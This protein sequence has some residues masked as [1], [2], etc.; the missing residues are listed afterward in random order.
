MHV[1][2]L[3]STHMECVCVAGGEGQNTPATVTPQLSCRSVSDLPLTLPRRNVLQIAPLMVEKA[4]RA[5]AD[6]PEG[7]QRS[8]V[9][10]SISETG[11]LVC[12][13]PC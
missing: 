6:K 12:A 5:G 4:A 11:E 13:G 2:L 10:F 9:N 1:M 3:L 8:K 7:H